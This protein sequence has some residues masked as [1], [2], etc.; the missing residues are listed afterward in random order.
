MSFARDPNGVATGF[1]LHQN[2]DHAAPKL[3][4]SELPSGLREIALDAGKLADYVGKCCWG[5][6]ATK[7]DAICERPG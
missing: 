5:G 1:V 6:F 7:T 3:S 4:A 2:G